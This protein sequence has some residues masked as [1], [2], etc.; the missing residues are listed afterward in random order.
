MVSRPAEAAPPPCVAP[1]PPPLTPPHTLGAPPPP[2]LP[3]IPSVYVS[4]SYFL[5]AV[6]Q[7]H[8]P[9][10]DLSPAVAALLLAFGLLAIYVNWAADAQR[11]HV[12]EAHPHALVW[13]AKPT[14]ILAKYSSGKEKRTSI[15]LASGWWG[16]ARHFHYLPEILASVAWSAPAALVGGG[17]ALVPWFY[18]AFLT[19]LLLDRAYRD[20]A[21]CQEK[22]GKSWDKYKALVPYRII[23]GVL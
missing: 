12:R 18:C 17:N 23:P 15:L 9:G 22:Y 1:L 19:V 21:R 16:V 20:D 14:V 2:H 6:G 3:R 8:Q 13:G 7:Q 5:A 11:A 4:H 10:G